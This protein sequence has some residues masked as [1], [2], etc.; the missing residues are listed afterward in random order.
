MND[1]KPNFFNQVDLI[2]SPLFMN[3]DF[4]LKDVK[5]NIKT[6]EGDGKILIEKKFRA[7][8]QLVDS[9][10]PPTIICV[11]DSN[12]SF[13]KENLK[14]K[15]INFSSVDESERVGSRLF[16]IMEYYKKE[17]NILLITPIFL[18]SLNLVR[19]N[20]IILFDFTPDLRDLLRIVS[21][22][23][24]SDG[25]HNNNYNNLNNGSSSNH[26]TS[27]QYLKMSLMKNNM[28]IFVDT[29]EVEKY[30]EILEH[31]SNIN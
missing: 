18:K 1:I 23:P 11:N 31:L 21:K 25:E 26:Q 28:H 19:L 15:R 7:L 17:T 6:F 2:I 12:I 10:S 24:K 20:Q 3:F 4:H 29:S 16:S 8:T 9:K 22:F 13:L 5:L 14:K 30:S 27:S